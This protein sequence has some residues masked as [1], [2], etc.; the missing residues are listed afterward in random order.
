MK[1]FNKTI[2]AIILFF[3]I[4]SLSNNVMAQSNKGRMAGQ[5]AGQGALIGAIAGAV[6]G[7]GDF[8][9]DA[10]EG[11]LIGG[12]IGALSG[13]LQGGRMDRQAQDELD[14]LVQEFGEDNLRGYIELMSCN[15]EKS[16]ALFK[17][18]E[19]SGNS[20]HR[21]AALWLQAV[22]EK[23]RRNLD[24]VN[25]LYP[26]LIENDRDIDDEQ[27]ASIAIDQ[28]VLI[29]REDRRANQLPSCR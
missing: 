26:T 19:V 1:N 12:G 14:Q 17:V 18:G 9:G 2:G 29:L 21:L 3:L 13:A 20:D 16:I 11:A 7:G 24:A 15:Y 22:A 4:I 28:Y 5:G 23:D 10:A 25:N 27:Q 6:F 8:I